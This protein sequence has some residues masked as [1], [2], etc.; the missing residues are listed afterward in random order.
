MH[1]R[2]DQA[3]PLRRAAAP[4]RAGAWLDAQA[5]EECAMEQYA[6][7]YGDWHDYFGS[8]T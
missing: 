2:L 1:G 6:A 4:G 5:W 3:A 8:Y 7:F